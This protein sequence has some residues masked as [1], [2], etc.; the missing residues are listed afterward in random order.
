M[1]REVLGDTQPADS[2]DS[3]SACAPQLS[4][5]GAGK[6]VEDDARGG[7]ALWA[8][9][10]LGYLCQ[11]RRVDSAPRPAVPGGP[12]CSPANTTSVIRAVLGAGTQR[13]RTHMTP[14]LKGLTVQLARHGPEQMP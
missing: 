12:L 6:G 2:P 11:G 5:S 1:F 7:R 8:G 9:L 14:A 4:G 10:L 13:G 3:P